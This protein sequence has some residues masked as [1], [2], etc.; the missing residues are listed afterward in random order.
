[1]TE[2]SVEFIQIHLIASCHGF[3]FNW[4]CA[5]VCELC[6]YDGYWERSEITWGIFENNR[7]LFWTAVG[8]RVHKR[9]HSSFTSISENFSEPSCFFFVFFFK[10]FSKTWKDCQHPL[11]EA[12]VKF[13]NQFDPK[14]ESQYTNIVYTVKGSE[15]IFGTV[16]V[17]IYHLT[18]V[19]VSFL[20][21]Q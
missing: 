20:P 2:H 1:M 8:Y 4:L 14:H 11:K 9:P 7:P 12:E 5:F 19:Y 6:S 13:W 18:I 15:E 16:A 21:C 3:N 10:K 17:I